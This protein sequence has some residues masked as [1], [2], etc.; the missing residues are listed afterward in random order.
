MLSKPKVPC[1]AQPSLTGFGNLP[2]RDPDHSLM[3]QQTSDCLA[4]R[5][6]RG[7]EGRRAARSEGK[8]MAA[9]KGLPP[10]I[11]CVPFQES[12][13]TNDVE[14]GSDLCVCGLQ[15]DRRA[16]EKVRSGRMDF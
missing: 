10:V 4:G 6:F 8:E 5:K 13:R 2:L 3:V 9:V 12:S 11:G 16:H 14:E 7:M 1:P 15:K